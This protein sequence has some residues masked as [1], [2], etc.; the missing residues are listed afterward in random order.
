ML[1]KV[2]FSMGY[3]YPIEKYINIIKKISTK[4]TK[5]ISDLSTEYNEQNKVK[6]YFNKV[7]IIQNDD[8]VKQNYLRLLC[9]DIK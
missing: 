3:H 2:S 6:K 1:M 5:V 4:R 8:E 7:V 9:S